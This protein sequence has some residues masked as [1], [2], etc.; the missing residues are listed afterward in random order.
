MTALCE[1]PN[2]GQLADLQKESGK[3]KLKEPCG[4]EGSFCKDPSATIN[5]FERRDSKRGVW[6]SRPAQLHHYSK[7]HSGVDLYSAKSNQMQAT[8]TVNQ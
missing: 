8:S 2:S 4:A 5:W 6:S 1:I 3:Q 7:M